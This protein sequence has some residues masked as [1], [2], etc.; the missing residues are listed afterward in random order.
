M[1]AHPSTAKPCDSH[2]Y[3]ADRSRRDTIA[4]TSQLSPPPFLVE[5]MPVGALPWMD[6]T[7]TVLFIASMLVLLTSVLILW[8]SRGK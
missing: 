1:T 8:S 7:V 6:L 3:A 2:A 4:T 5:R